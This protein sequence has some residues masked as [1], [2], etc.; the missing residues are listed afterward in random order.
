M[1]PTCIFLRAAHGFFAFTANLHVRPFS[2]L[3]FNYSNK[4]D[5]VLVVVLLFE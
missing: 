1:Y 5:A 2:Y 4:S 3:P